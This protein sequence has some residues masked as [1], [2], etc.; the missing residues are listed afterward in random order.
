MK[1]KVLRP[2]L[3]TLTQQ[4]KEHL[5]NWSKK[6]PENG[7]VLYSS[8]AWVHVTNA[9]Q[10]ALVTQN[11]TMLVPKIKSAL[12]RHELTQYTVCPRYL[13]CLLCKKINR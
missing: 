5:C 7:G 13:E 12:V 1:E 2:Y 4:V 8:Y 10:E 6:S 3:F 9:L 11:L